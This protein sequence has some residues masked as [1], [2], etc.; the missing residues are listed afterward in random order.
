MARRAH[1]L[2]K[3]TVSLPRELVRY[4]DS[5]AA[6]RATSRSAV[7]SDALA[8]LR[9]RQE[10]ELAREGYAFYAEESA[11]F[12]AASMKAVSEAFGRAC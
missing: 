11:E 2:E 4:A 7:V 12:A 9:E 5:L 8:V 1:D 3:V 10:S 6:E